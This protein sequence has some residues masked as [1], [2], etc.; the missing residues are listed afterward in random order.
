MNPGTGLVLN[1][2]GQEGGKMRGI[3]CVLDRHHWTIGETGVL[4]SPR[5]LL[6]WVPTSAFYVGTAGF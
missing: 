6:I 4:D 1:T 2:A 5:R 3:R